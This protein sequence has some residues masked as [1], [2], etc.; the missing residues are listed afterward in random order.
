[1]TGQG[2]HAAHHRVAPRSGDGRRRGELPRPGDSRSE[3]L[4]VEELVKVF[5]V[6]RGILRRRG[7][8]VRAVDGVSLSVDRGQTLGLVGESACGKSTVARCI[9]RLVEPTSGRI[10]FGGEDVS[11][12]GPEALRRYRQRVQMVFQDPFGTLNPR[13]T[14][15]QLIAEP[16]HAHGLVG[17]RR[18]ARLRVAELLERVGLDPGRAGRYPHEF[19]G[20]QRQRIAI[21]RALSTRPPMLIL[22]E[23]VAALDVSIGAQ[24]LNLLT[25]LQAE[26]GV[27]YLFISHDLSLVRHLAHRVAV[28]YLG[29]IMEVADVRDLFQTPRHPYT[30]ALLSAVPLPDPIQERGRRRIPLPGEPPSSLQ[31][32][33]AC[34]FHTRCFKAEPVCSQ[35]EPPLAAVAERNHR[36]SCWFSEPIP[37]L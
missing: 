7:G 36:A 29:A 26:L 34:R 25:D 16:L 13:M 17:G 12:Y 18:A 27:A 28:M 5:P 4:L 23:P 35:Q 32:P 6:T 22:D 24:I 14:V 3:L 15:Q 11:G 1:M 30:Q 8:E 31:V 9:L 33:P 10:R 19:S 20:G 2:P 37:V 21:A